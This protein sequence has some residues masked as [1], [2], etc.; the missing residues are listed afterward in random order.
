MKLLRF[1]IVFAASDL[2]AES[3]FWAAVFNG[4]VLKDTEWHSRLDKDCYNQTFLFG[5]IELDS[6]ET[7]RSF[8]E[9]MVGV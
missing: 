6:G 1:V 8:G 4:F 9:K 5:G 7:E 2:D 3:A